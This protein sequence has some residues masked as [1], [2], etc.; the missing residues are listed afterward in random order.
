VDNYR[1]Y[2]KE[3][4]YF[5]FSRLLNAVPKIITTILAFKILDVIFLC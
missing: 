4:G 5:G 2:I 3:S 1:V